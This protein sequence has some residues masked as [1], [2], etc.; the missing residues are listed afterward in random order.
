MCHLRIVAIFTVLATVIAMSTSTSAAPIPQMEWIKTYDSPAHCDDTGRGVAVDTLGYIYVT[1]Y[2]DRSDLGQGFNVW[3]RKYDGNGNVVWT[4]T[5]DSPAH[6]S[7]ISR[8][9]AV[10]AY[11]NIY[12]TGS[13]YRS[14]LNQDNNI[15]LR[16]YDSDGN[17]IW[18]RTYDSLAH[19]E[20]TGMAVSVDIMGNVIVTGYEDRADLSQGFNLWLREYDTNGNTVWTQTYDCQSHLSNMGRGVATDAQGNVYVTGWE[21]RSD[22]GQDRNVFLSKYDANGNL[23]WLQ[24]YDSPAHSFDGGYGVAVDAAGNAYVVGW[25]NRDDLNQYRNILLQKY[26]TNGNVIWT[27]TY[28]SPGHGNDEGFGVTVDDAGN[29]YVAGYEDRSDL[30]QGYN[31]WL[32]KYDSSGGIIWTQTYDSPA[33]CLDNGWSVVVDNTGNVYVT[34][35]EYR[36]DLDQN[37][38]VILLKYS[39]V[40]EPGTVV[41]MAG[42]VLA[43]AGIAVRKIRR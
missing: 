39:Q 21:N 22:L 37:Y 43:C 34:G 17:A 9:L 13:E 20:D 42:A 4:Q 28:D 35:Y 6:Q 38:N 24:S 25:E 16:K 30:N 10:D 19:R 40:P 18:T 23:L 12:V 31:I 26:D 11:G 15:W 14:D 32:R 3:L 29:V 5:Y 27:Q 7:D 8:G 2:E 1:G 41:L 33:Y 36:D